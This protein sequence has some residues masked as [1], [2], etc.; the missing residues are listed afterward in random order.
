[1]TVPLSTTL[2]RY[3]SQ[4]NTSGLAADS[5]KPAMVAIYTMHDKTTGKETQGLSVS[6]DTQTFDFYNQN[7][8]H[9]AD[10]SPSAT[11]R[12]FITQ[13]TDRWIM[14]IALLRSVSSFLCL[15]RL[16][17]WQFLSDFGPAGAM[18]QLWE[19]PDLFQLSIDGDPSRKSGCFCAGWGQTLS[20]ILSSSL[21][22]PFYPRPNVEC[23]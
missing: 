14:V 12:C 21:M 2:V 15:S 23:V 19:V 5:K 8:V 22:Y 17:S 16:K 18:S 4:K 6:Q 10:Q 3:G 1:M 13:K 7:P 9:T 11:R 20:S